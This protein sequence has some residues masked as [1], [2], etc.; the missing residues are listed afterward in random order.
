MGTLATAPE[1]EVFTSVLGQGPF[2]GNITCR[3]V[4]PD[5]TIYLN[6]YNQ[7]EAYFILAMY[8]VAKEIQ[9]SQ[10]LQMKLEQPYNYG[11]QVIK[12]KQLPCVAELKSLTPIVANWDQP[13]TTDGT[14]YF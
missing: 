13:L 12:N 10:G 2:G 11:G 5:H 4:C 14:C 3:D 9:N 7:G 1:R 6:S 8:T